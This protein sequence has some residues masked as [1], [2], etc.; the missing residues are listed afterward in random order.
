MRLA[1]LVNIAALLISG[2]GLTPVHH[3]FGQS[4]PLEFLTTAPAI[5]ETRQQDISIVLFDPGIPE[6]TSTHRQ[7]AVFPQVRAIEA[8]FLPFV[9][10]EILMESDEWGAVRVVP[11]ASPGDEI[12]IRGLIRKSNGEKLEVQLQAH[13]AFGNEWAKGVYSMTSGSADPNNTVEISNSFQNVFRQF[14]ADLV[15]ARSAYPEAQLE[16]NREVA[17]LR[18][19][20]NLLPKA[21]GP[22]LKSTVDNRYE[23]A[24]LPAKE[25]PMLDRITRI[26]DFEYKFIDAIDEQYS[27][28]Y[29]KTAQSYNLWL[30]YQERLTR[31]R[32]NG[33]ARRRNKEA[34]D[35]PG[36]Y[37]AMKESY[38]HYKWLKMEE[39]NLRRWALGFR[40]EVDPTVVEV[41]GR[42]VELD[43]SLEQRY[44]EW[45]DI[46]RSILE[47]ETGSF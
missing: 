39:Q 38:E 28:L 42:V 35:R 16:R 19:A 1:Y 40:N 3:V 47:S 2:L 27:N 29:L 22:Y 18:Y 24:R 32:L 12:S 15:I 34:T 11:H 46:L 37:S 26:R 44:Q 10:R 7:L 23:L 36:S 43:G 17:R 4:T 21:Y 6:D 30:R 41:E 45:R 8:R 31:Y 13:D 5:Q 25:D 14:A 20:G 33:E 9:L